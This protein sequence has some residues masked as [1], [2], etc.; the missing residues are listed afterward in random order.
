MSTSDRKPARSRPRRLSTIW[1]R[2]ALVLALLLASAL[3]WGI[4]SLARLEPRRRTMERL[5]ECGC[6]IAPPQFV[7]GVPDSFVSRQIDALERNRLITSMRHVFRV[8]WISCDGRSSSQ[9]SADLVYFPEVK[10]L[11]L[12]GESASDP[13]LTHLPTRRELETFSLRDSGMSTVSS[14]AMVGLRGMP[15]LRILDLSSTNRISGEGLRYLECDESLEEVN[16]WMALGTTDAGLKEL[17]RFKNLKTLN[18][19]IGGADLQGHG[20]AVLGELPNLQDVILPEEYREFWE[21]YVTHIPNV[22]TE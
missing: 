6:T 20:F 1:R 12:A 5:S 15:H 2:V 17:G 9:L 8:E 21:P 13:V 11:G 10:M 19:S 3:L 4:I 14:G 18:L 22:H 7:A 16:L